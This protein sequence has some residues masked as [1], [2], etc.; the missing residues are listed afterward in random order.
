MWRS[1]QRL[2]AFRKRRLESRARIFLVHT[3]K[4][5]PITNKLNTIGSNA[6]IAAAA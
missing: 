4:S 5:Q 6:T 1:A 2:T 3:K